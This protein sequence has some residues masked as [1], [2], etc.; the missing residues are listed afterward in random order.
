[1]TTITISNGMNEL[2]NALKQ[3]VTSK[4]VTVK[5]QWFDNVVADD[6]FTQVL[7]CDAMTIALSN[8]ANT[9]VDDTHCV[10]KGTT[11][12]ASLGTISTTITVTLIDNS[13]SLIFDATLAPNHQPEGI[14]SWL[15]STLLNQFSFE[16]CTLHY[17][18]ADPSIN[19]LTCVLTKPVDASIKLTVSFID[20][21]C[22]LDYKMV[23][24]L[25]IPGVSS[26]SITDASGRLTYHKGS[27][28][29]GDLSATCEIGSQSF[30]VSLC[31]PSGSEDVLLTYK[32]T[33]NDP[34][35]GCEQL[36]ASLPE[37]DVLTHALSALDQAI[38]ETGLT[39]TELKFDLNRS[40]LT[41]LNFDVIVTL[42]KDWSPLAG[43]TLAQPQIKLNYQKGASSS[44]NS[45]TRATLQSNM[46]LGSA[47]FNVS[48]LLPGL[49][50]TCVLEDE[51]SVTLA[52]L[53][54]GFGV[55]FTGFP[56]ATLTDVN[57]TGDID[58][59]TVELTANSAT[60][61]TFS[62]DGITL[63]LT[64]TTIEISDVAGQCTGT[65][66]G[67]V[68]IDDVALSVTGAATEDGWSLSGTTDQA[69]SFKSIVLSIFSTVH[70]TVDDALPDISLKSTRMSWASDSDTLAFKAVIATE[71]S[72][73][74][75]IASLSLQG[76][77]VEINR[78]KG[79]TTGTIQGDITLGSLTV[80]IDYD[81]SKGTDFSTSL[82]TVSLSKLIKTLCGHDL[83]QTLALP[84][85][86]ADF[87]LDNTHMEINLDSGYADITA[88]VDGYGSILLKISKDGSDWGFIFAAVT[89]D[90][91][92]F[93]HISSALKPIDSLNF[94]D[95][96]L[97]LS[98]M[99]STGVTVR[100]SP[101][102]TTD[103][104]K[105]LSFLMSL[106]M[107]NNA[108]LK[109]IKNALKL[110]I[111]SLV[112]TLAIQSDDNVTLEGEFGGSYDLGA[113]IT[114]TKTG[115]SM[116]LL[117]GNVIFSVDLQAAV[118]IGEILTFTG[119]LSVE[120]NGVTLAATLLGDW[121]RPFGV[122]G[123]T[124]SNL[125]LEVGISDE[126]IPDVGITGTVSVNNLSGRIAV[127]FNSEAPQ[128]SA[129]NLAFSEFDIKAIFEMCDPA[130]IKA[131]P[132]ELVA[133]LDSGYHNVDIYVVP[134]TTQIGGITFDEGFRAKGT[135]DILGWDAST[136]IDIDPAKGIKAK[137]QMEP[138]N[139]LNIFT[140]EG[141][142][143]SAYPEFDL[144]LSL[145]QQKATIAGAISFLGL[146]RYAINGQFSSAGFSFSISEMLF[147]VVQLALS[148]CILNKKMFNADG[149]I[150]FGIKAIGPIYIRSVK[151]LDKIP[152]NTDL[153][154][155]ASL[156]IESGFKLSLDGQL[157]VA[158]YGLP[159][160]SLT[161][162]EAPSDF[163]AVFD[164]LVEHITKSVTK[165]FDKIWDTIDAWAT[166]ISTR[167]LEFSGDVA[168]VAKE[169]FNA[170]EQEMI[171]ASRQLNR[172]VDEVATGLK[173]VYQL[174]DKATSKALKEANYAAKDVAGAM[175]SVYKLS[176]KET[177]YVLHQAGYA[178]EDVAGA[179]SSVYHFS[180][181]V[182]ADALKQAGYAVDDVGNAL[183][184]TYNLST[185]LAG[186]AL[187]Q[188]GYAVNDIKNWGG[189]AT[190]WI[191]GAGKTISRMFKRW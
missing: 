131:M 97:I 22:S 120:V 101:K 121:D 1:M 141:A 29:T 176:G 76:L 74:L 93:S 155:N 137:G 107:N 19:T 26:L 175:E 191:K 100:E 53:T 71:S 48:A 104:T 90:D 11:D 138:V 139:L 88:D 179:M 163:K 12:L 57:L 114:L 153:T 35:S 149:Y 38:A 177:V 115:L 173:E 103:V 33:T 150:L 41:L 142:G 51:Q 58:K 109:K 161:L 160:L 111:D 81:L 31:A 54:S 126:A 106:S 189:D 125:A 73:N 180:S 23:S 154:M 55:N 87:T 69:I 84:E 190:N 8:A 158:G 157:K 170:T 79:K 66:G 18:S 67:E 45:S 42:L 4:K 136:D 123:L 181:D 129:L 113:G 28:F 118:D 105:G 82:G 21:T 59:K 75:G 183:K 134:T 36:L 117:S 80:A 3:G 47:K 24:P 91:F 2:I 83:L 32:S 119:K 95:T 52:D 132:S 17:S 147:G 6:F 99:Q 86:I 68:S 143:T 156:T 152:I 63:D 186:K 135:I 169:V 151:V 182:T 165:S 89:G 116:Q 144:V 112:T 70:L 16:S 110:N 171:H 64:E 37:A 145:E 30:P 128:Q 167:G 9:I 50:L 159:A 39:L 5:K 98:S 164:H 124:L 172:D 72:I 162:S 27:D 185:K 108:D 13:E 174:G 94:Q 146:N 49:T 140:L 10:I 62:I 60:N 78:A 46:T 178:A 85:R 65:I 15:K 77:T 56:A 34:F 92:H 7:K 133:L 187:Q 25:K 20:E 168:E 44:S 96:T 61:L 130:I 188:A 127:L 14:F 40:T 184:S 43:L 122:R 102:L 148:H 166:S